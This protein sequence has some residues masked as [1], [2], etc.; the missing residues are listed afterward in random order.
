MCKFDS[1]GNGVIIFLYVDDML[2]FVIDLKEVE[3]TNAFLFTSFSMKR[4]G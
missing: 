2:I 1:N 3:K 4:F